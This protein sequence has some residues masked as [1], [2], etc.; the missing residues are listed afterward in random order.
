LLD[1]KRWSS[2]FRSGSASYRN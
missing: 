2:T 1:R